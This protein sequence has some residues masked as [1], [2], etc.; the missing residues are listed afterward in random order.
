MTKQHIF[1]KKE[2]RRLVALRREKPAHRPANQKDKTD[3]SWKECYDDI[4]EC[5]RCGKVTTEDSLH[6]CTP[7]EDK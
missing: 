3:W 7:K 2:A 5:P 1:K 6:T 4:V